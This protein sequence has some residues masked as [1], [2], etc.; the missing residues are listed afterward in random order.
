MQ[1]AD[2]AADEFEVFAITKNVSNYGV[3]A[4]GLHNVRPTHPDTSQYPPSLMLPWTWYK[5]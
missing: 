4:N 2:I 5:D 1:I 3:K